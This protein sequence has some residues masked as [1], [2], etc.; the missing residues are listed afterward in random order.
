MK[1][2]VLKQHGGLGD[3]AFGYDLEADCG[4]GGDVLAVGKAEAAFAALTKVRQCR[5]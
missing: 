2:L 1:A 4:V 3:L 5:T